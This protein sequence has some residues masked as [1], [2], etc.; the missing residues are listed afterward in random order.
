VVTCPS[1]N[2]KFM[3]LLVSVNVVILPE[4]VRE[5]SVDR[6]L[7]MAVLPLKKT[8]NVDVD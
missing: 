5:V 3:R 7:T 8:V 6:N 4:H 1:L 2:V